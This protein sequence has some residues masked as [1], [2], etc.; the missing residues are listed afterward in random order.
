MTETAP[1]GT[2]AT[3]QARARR[4]DP[5]TSGYALP[6]DAG[7]PVAARR[8]RVRGRRRRGRLGRRD[9]GRAPGPRPVGRR[10]ATT[11]AEGA[12]KFT[13]DG[14][15]R[16]GDVATI[17]ARGYIRIVDRTKD[18]IKSG[19]EWISSVDMENALMAHRGG[20]GGRGDRRPR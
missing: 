3:L 5:T 15:L 8:A 20:R 16:T 9:D 13:A 10:R 1:L 11:A 19:G 7:M 18:L 12:D 4:R 6:R 14:W 17:D 2:V